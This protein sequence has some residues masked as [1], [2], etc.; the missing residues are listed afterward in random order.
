MNSVAI[1][2][3]GIT[4]LTA[5]LRLKQRG[6]PVVV[7]EAGERVGGVIQTIQRDGFLVE[8]GPNTILE[9]SP[10]IT[11][12]VRDLG[13]AEMKL[14]T[15][16]EA[17]NRYVV[18]N[19][20]LIRVPASPGDF[21]RSRLFSWSG[22]MRLA[23][24]PLIARAHPDADESL[25]SFVLRRI[26]REP[27]DYA[28]NPFVAGV[29]AGDPARL[30]VRHAFPKLHAVEQRYGSLLI[31]QFLGAR[32]RKRRG[33]VSKQNA[34]KFSFAGGLQTLTERMGVELRNN[35]HLCTSVTA[36][37][38]GA[39]GW[40]IAGSGAARTEHRHSAVLLAAPAHRL[41][42]IFLHPQN[43]NARLDRLA[44]IHYAPVTTLALGFKREQVSHAMDG[45]G[46]LIPKVEPF[47]ILG[48]LFTSSLFPNRAPD[49]HVLVTCYLGGARCPEL[50][51]TTLE[52][53]IELAMRDLTTLLGI[54]GAP[55]FVHRSTF[56]QAIPQY[57]VGFGEF[58]D[59]MSRIEK[60]AP[61][62]F[63]AG[64]YRDGIS[65]G[66]SIVSGHHTAERMAAFLSRN[67]SDGGATEQA[68]VCASTEQC[69]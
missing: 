62:V 28:I 6:I 16:P 35:I 64:H 40:T 48:A 43:N 66:D 2:G 27:L 37:T 59:L 51:T 67:A 4:G 1:I 21:L 34:P 31:G 50:A 68:L 45:F 41:A 24:E 19:S 7:Y 20:E 65:L 15:A 56:R 22:K 61:G 8:C 10:A 12:L 38:Q 9:T 5:A 26:G 52:R 69:P 44:R 54:R 17:S 49:G 47:H 3:A 46:V 18:R 13:L 55:V 36:I 32:E 63:L 53:Q 30:S 39:G 25:E 29:Y 57:D 23:L 33:E 42:Q 58:K 11:E 60:T 14:Y